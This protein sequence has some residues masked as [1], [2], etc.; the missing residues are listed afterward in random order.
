MKIVA[1]ILVALCLMIIACNNSTQNND[2]ELELMLDSNSR[3]ENVDSFH[4]PSNFAYLSN[5]PLR[6]VA[7]LILLDSITP[8]DNDITFKCMD[9]MLNKQTE[10]RDFYFPVFLKIMSKSDGALSE[11]VCGYAKSYVEQ[12]T[13]EFTNRYKLLSPPQIE[14][15]A[16]FVGFELSFDY[17]SKKDAIVWQDSV[18]K[19]CNSCDSSQKKIVKTFTGKAIAS[20]EIEE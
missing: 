3:A 12:Y 11:A 9:S 1:S 16:G 20:M 14:K 13:T 19:L 6:N 8:S 5:L 4:N 2:N 17:E 10:I 7:T 15:W 18:M